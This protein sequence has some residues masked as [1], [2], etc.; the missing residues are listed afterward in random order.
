MILI[1]SLKSVREKAYLNFLLLKTNANEKK[2][3]L[4]AICSFCFYVP[5][6]GEMS[7]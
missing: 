5:G 4:F 3:T 7:V 1:T 6:P 2:S